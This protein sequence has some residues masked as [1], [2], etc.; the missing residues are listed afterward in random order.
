MRLP[1]SLI[2]VLG[3]SGSAYAD[4]Q[5]TFLNVSGG[6][7]SSAQ[8]PGDILRTD[9]ETYDFSFNPGVTHQRSF[10]VGSQSAAGIALATGT[11]QVTINRGPDG[12]IFFVRATGV[13]SSTNADGEASATATGD[14]RFDFV[15]DSATAGPWTLN[16]NARTPGDAL[17]IMLASVS[18]ERVGGP[19]F[20]DLLL[21][22]SGQDQGGHLDLMFTPGTYS[23][24]AHVSADAT[25]SGL[26]PGL[27]AEG[28]VLF[29]MIPT[30]APGAA[31]MLAIAAV[32]AVM[33]RRRFLGH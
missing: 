26:N 33:R 14:I 20:I 7:H 23:I 3:I 28:R 31:V 17:G 32:P 2:A 27:T 15:V 18:F 6:A 5:W 12:V 16:Y 24:Q 21:D 19:R 9:G 11:D 8:V 25:I 4:L 30:P 22:T 13:V 1:I 10:P 29:S